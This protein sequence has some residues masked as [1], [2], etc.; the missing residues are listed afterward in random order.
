MGIRPTVLQPKRSPTYYQDRSRI[1]GKTYGERAEAG[2]KRGFWDSGLGT[3]AKGVGAAVAWPLAS[4]FAPKELVSAAKWAKRAKDIKE[5]KGLMG[6]I[7][8]KFGV[9]EK[10]SNLTSTIDK[11]KA[12]KFTGSKYD[13]LNPNEMKNVRTRDDTPTSD[14]EA[15]N[16]KTLAQTV[17]QGTGLQSGQDL[18][19][20]DDEQIKN[21]YAVQNELNT[22]ID[23]G[24]YQGK[25]LTT[26]QIKLLQNKQMELNNLIQAIEKAKAPVNVAYGGRIDKAFTGR[27]RDI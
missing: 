24:V 3:L 9:N 15:V 1:D 21:L 16:R 11:A 13:K 23:A 10:F 2:M 27:S 22:T 7:A 17:T 5:G 4:A 18:L 6:K 20:L 14:G 19:G 25:Q 8:T 26:D 12:A